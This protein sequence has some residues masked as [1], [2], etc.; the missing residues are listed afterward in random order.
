VISALKR[1]GFVV[2]QGGNHTILE[3]PDGRYTTIPRHSRINPLTLKS[4]LKQ[5][6]LTDEEFLNL[7]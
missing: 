5:C 1:A 3:H 7:Y 2:R 6:G 4:I